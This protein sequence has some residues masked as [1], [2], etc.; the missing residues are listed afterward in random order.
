MTGN[1]KKVYE[2]FSD[3]MFLDEAERTNKYGMTLIAF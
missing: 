2:E 1:M 3:F